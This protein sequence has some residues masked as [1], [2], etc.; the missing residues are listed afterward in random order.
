MLYLN[1]ADSVFICGDLNARVGNLYDHIPDIDPL[2]ESN[3][4]LNCN[5]TYDE[6]KAAVSRA[7]N[8]KA[9][10]IDKIPN[11]VLK[12][13]PVIS[14]LHKLFQLIFDSS[15][16]PSLWR[17]AIIVP[18]PKDPK[19]DKRV[20]LHYRGISL[21]CCISKIYTSV[22]NN[23]IISYY[24]SSEVEIVSDE[25]NGFRRKRS[26][27]E[28]LFSVTS[29]ICNRLH[30]K[31]STFV[32]FIDLKKA[33][34][35][36]DRQLLMYRLLLAGIDDK[37]Y[38]SIRELYS[39]TLS[40]VKVNHL[41]TEWFEAKS[42]VRQGD[43]L[44]PTLFNI[45]I[46]N[47]IVKVK[48]TGIG[49]KVGEKICNIF[50]YADDIALMASTENDLQTLLD[51][52]GDWCTDWN[53]VINAVKSKVIHF[54]N[55]NKLQTQHTFK[56]NNETIEQISKYKYLGLILH[57]NLNFSVTC[58]VLAKA[59]GR[60]LGSVTSKMKLIENLGY[61]TYNQLFTSGVVSV[62]DYGA[63]IW[64]YKDHNSAKKVT[65]NAI[66]TFLGVHKF[67][68][69]ASLYG[70][71][72]WLKPQYRRWL[73]MIRL[74]NRL[75]SMDNHRVT[76]HVFLWDYNICND[77]WSNEVKTILNSIDMQN[78]FETLTPCNIHAASCRLFEKFEGEWRNELLSKPKLRVYRLFKQSLF[79]ENYVLI[80]LSR[81]ERSVA[82]QFRSGI[83][84]LRIETGRYQGE[85]ENERICV[86]C[87]ANAIENEY[88]FCLHCS[89]YMQLRQNIISLLDNVQTNMSEDQKLMFLWENHPRQIS[90]FI[91][92]AYLKRK[93]QLYK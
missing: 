26:C 20:P 39:S 81:F 22:L 15:K 36:V 9:V 28:H 7:K 61:N 71:I 34:D 91:A 84:P 77:N 69:L 93:K 37:M 30:E 1:E 19:N 57:E 73:C 8:G 52:V 67:A 79:T 56:L 41:Q 54:R 51:V 53:L 62:M 2:Y 43:S 76:K 13:N 70:D 88:H 87:D 16:I 25:Q 3:E 65:Q 44:S 49:V 24:D 82:A 63:E 11:E 48:N 72:G 46:N 47:L 18:I 59:S 83:L 80:N 45:F 50:L 32:A 29:I 27:N 6:I 75:V 86:F 14:V 12:L 68:P 33:F 55:K 31:S 23:R 10:G 40:C 85:S 42:G 60:A 5:I 74:W 90:K 21:L 66:R 35:F 17:K 78:N 64:G 92:S 38:K 4:M 89:N 58:D